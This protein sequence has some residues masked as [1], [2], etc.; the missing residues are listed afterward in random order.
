MPHNRITVQQ[1]PDGETSTC[2]DWI[3]SENKWWHVERPVSVEMGGITCT[4]TYECACPKCA[5][6][7]PEIDLDKT[8][9]GEEC[10]GPYGKHFWSVPNRANQV[11]CLWC[12][13]RISAGDRE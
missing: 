1:L 9:S 6:C 7:L 5:D 4:G 10:R 2:D 3:F 12:N 11:E 8:A 13:K